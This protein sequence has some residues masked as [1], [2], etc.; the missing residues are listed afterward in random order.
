MATS[1]ASTPSPVAAWSSALP[2]P[3]TLRLASA[4]GLTAATVTPERLELI[5]FQSG[6]GISRGD[7][8]SVLDAVEDQVRH[9]EWGAQ[10]GGGSW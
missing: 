1:S 5:G 10:A 3:P 4:K 8:N 6:S 9:A 2:W 7:F